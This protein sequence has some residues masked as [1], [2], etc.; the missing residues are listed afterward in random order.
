MQREAGDKRVPLGSSG[1][2]PGLSGRQEDYT[3]IPIP[4][5][6]AC[7]LVTQSQ[8]SVTWA[9]VRSP[10]CGRK[11]AG[12]AGAPVTGSP[13]SAPHCPSLVLGNTQEWAQ[14]DKEGSFPHEKE[15]RERSVPF[16]TTGQM[17]CES[18]REPAGRADIPMQ[19]LPGCMGW[20][21]PAGLCHPCLAPVGTDNGSHDVCAVPPWGSFLMPMRPF[22]ARTKDK[23]SPTE[24]F[25]ARWEGMEGN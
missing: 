7:N 14:T 18:E 6:H 13:G 2:E 15:L 10:S 22:V 19:T 11:E 12:K 25:P 5:R 3:G 9:F 4:P 8:W 23:S 21:L 17:E 20:R 1:S 24:G 16:A